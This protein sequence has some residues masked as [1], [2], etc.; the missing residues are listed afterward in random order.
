M[1]WSKLGLPCGLFARLGV[2]VKVT[3]QA[4]IDW[5]FISLEMAAS[6]PTVLPASEMLAGIAIGSGHFCIS[7]WVMPQA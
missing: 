7:F 3:V 4:N 6:V 2:T 1:P 5:L